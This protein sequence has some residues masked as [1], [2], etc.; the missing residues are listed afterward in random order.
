MIQKFF[1]LHKFSEIGEKNIFVA[2]IVQNLENGN[3]QGFIDCS[4]ER[5]HVLAN[6][7]VPSVVHALWTR[8]SQRIHLGV[9]GNAVPPRLS[10]LE[11]V[12]TFRENSACADLAGFLERFSL[13]C[14]PNFRLTFPVC[15]WGTGTVEPSHVATKSIFDP[16]PISQIQD[17]GVYGYSSVIIIQ[18]TRL[19]CRLHCYKHFWSFVDIC[20]SLNFELIVLIGSYR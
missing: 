2:Q 7:A 17:R 6:I 4:R 20:G 5:D 1:R 14:K 15:F 18:F 13:V 12:G 19:I 9:S 11:K 8:W 10:P 16:D 3:F